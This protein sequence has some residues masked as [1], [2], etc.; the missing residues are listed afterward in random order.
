ML[1]IPAIAGP[2]STQSP[3]DSTGSP[4]LPP[5]VLT[6][7]KQVRVYRI[8]SCEIF[9]QTAHNI[10]TAQDSDVKSIVVEYFLFV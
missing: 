5:I 4:A 9:V 6:I 7:G 3:P 1:Y 2:P 10:R 8:A